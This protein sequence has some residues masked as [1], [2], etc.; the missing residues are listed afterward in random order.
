MALAHLIEIVIPDLDRPLRLTIT[1][2]AV[3]N[4][5]SPQAVEDR[6]RAEIAA[7]GITLPPT[8]RIEYSGL[9]T[10]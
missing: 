2:P 1:L 3:G 5:A 4:K 10:Y 6:A 8:A 7:A 9:V